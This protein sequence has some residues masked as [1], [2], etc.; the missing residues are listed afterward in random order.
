MFCSKDWGIESVMTNI[1]QQAHLKGHKVLVLADGSR[2]SSAQYD[3]EQEIE[4][5]RF[6]QL[7]FLRKKLNPT[8]VI[9]F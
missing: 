1:A 7:K 6:D 4:I 9:P 5:K 2:L 3:Q 8:F